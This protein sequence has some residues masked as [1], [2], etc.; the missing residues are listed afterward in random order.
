MGTDRRRAI[1][2]PPA[3]VSGVRTG[4]W[5]R[6]RRQ[7]FDNQTV[8]IWGLPMNYCCIAE[9]QAGEESAHTPAAFALDGVIDG[10]RGARA[11]WRSSQPRALAY[12]S[13]GFPSRHAIGVIMDTLSAALFPI[14]LGPAEL[15]PLSEDQ[16]VRASLLSALPLLAAQLTME[17]EYEQDL[18]GTAGNVAAD[19]QRIVAGLAAQL[20]DI[21]RVLDTDLAAAFAGDPAARSVD[22]VLLCY[23]CVTAIIHHRI[24]HVLYRLGAP[25]VARI[26]AETAHS[27]TGIDIHP[28]AAIGDSFFI[29]HGTGVVIGQTAIIGRRVRIYQ[30]VTLGARR[31]ATDADGNL[32]NQPRHPIIEDDVTIYSGATILGRITV[33]QGSVIGGNVWLTRSVPAGSRVR[34][35]LAKVDIEMSDPFA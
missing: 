26:I 17:L 11:Q 25:L 1:S 14:R 24:A 33:G 23:P 8:L 28:G 31:F 21:R 32:V 13:H 15:T 9:P 29:D 6:I 20:P 35:Q 16:F 7:E 5:I 2:A 30:A 19:V 3:A 10:L 4:A 22:E 34:Q 27:R 18:S 12:G